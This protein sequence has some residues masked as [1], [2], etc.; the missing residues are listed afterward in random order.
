MKIISSKALILIVVGLFTPTTHAFL[1]P[2]QKYKVRMERKARYE[3]PDHEYIYYNKIKNTVYGALCLP[4]G[5]IMTLDGFFDSDLST[6]EK[7]LFSFAGPAITFGSIKLL[8]N[9]FH[10]G[11]AIIITDAGIITNET[12]LTL[13]EEINK[14]V[15]DY[16]NSIITLETDESSILIMCSVLNIHIDTFLVKINR[17]KKINL[18]GTTFTIIHDD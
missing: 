5:F 15:I 17:F 18:A 14:G 2:K 10:P 6:L 13:W 16:T 1:S 8:E 3:D 12:G 11:P 9:A 4:L 7:L